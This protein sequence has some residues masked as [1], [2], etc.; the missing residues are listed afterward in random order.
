M[1]HVMGALLI[2]VPELLTTAVA[3]TASR[4]D[5]TI[6]RGHVFASVRPGSRLRTW[7]A[8][9]VGVQSSTPSGTAEAPERSVSD[10]I[11]ITSPSD[12]TPI[13]VTVAVMT[14]WSP[15]TRG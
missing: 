12:K 9:G 15:A 2:T 10:S 5:W 7:P 3:N 4:P 8:S 6:R 14:A 13:F 1:S 11:T